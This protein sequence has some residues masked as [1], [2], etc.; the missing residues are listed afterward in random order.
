MEKKDFKVGQDV[1]VKIVEGSNRAR[2]MNDKSN[3]D[4]WIEEKIVTKIG[5]KYI[6]V[7]NKD[8]KEWGIE[9]F[10]ITNNFNHYYT[11]GGQDYELYLSREDILKDIKS[12]RLYRE[13]KTRFSDWKNKQRYTLE[14]LESINKIINN[15]IN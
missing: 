12:E 3:I 7:A 9:K 11:C 13:I 6:T 4:N 10:D 5:N 15:N 2:R 14:Q 1:Y 8:D